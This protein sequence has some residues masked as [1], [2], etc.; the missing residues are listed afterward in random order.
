[1]DVASPCSSMVGVLIANLVQ[2]GHLGASLLG[3]IKAEGQCQRSS[4]SFVCGLKHLLE[5]PGKVDLL[6]LTLNTEVAQ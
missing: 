5:S 4:R 1:M 3:L 6:T 2:F